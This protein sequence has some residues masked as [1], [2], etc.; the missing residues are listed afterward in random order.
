MSKSTLPINRLET[1]F[2]ELDAAKNAPIESTAIR[3]DAECRDL[4]ADAYDVLFNKTG[5]KIIGQSS[6]ND[7]MHPQGSTALDVSLPPDIT[8]ADAKILI[9]LEGLPVE[10]LEIVD[11]PKRNEEVLWYQ[12]T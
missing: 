7:P 9:Y 10:E 3:I 11:V 2:A 12:N 4:V 6:L 1:Y 5:A 8:I